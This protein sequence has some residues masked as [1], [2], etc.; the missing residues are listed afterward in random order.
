M[1]PLDG[2]YRD[3]VRDHTAPPVNAKIDE[4]TEA[5]I[6]RYTREQVAKISRRLGDLDR[7][8]DIDRALMLNFAVLGG[9]ALGLGRRKHPAFHLVLGAQ[10][11]F[12][13]LHAIVGWCP[14]VPIFRRLGFRTQKE[15]NVER[16]ALMD[17][18]D[19]RLPA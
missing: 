15:I 1:G 12:L 14:P 6:R 2:I 16:R 7:E 17:T 4:R 18:L 8:W 10:L 13:A 5:N 11:A 3:R 9:T 19:A